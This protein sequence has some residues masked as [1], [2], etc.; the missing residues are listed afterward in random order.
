MNCTSKLYFPALQVISRH[1]ASRVSLAEFAVLN[2][3]VDRTWRYGKEEELVT[4]TQMME[5]IVDKKTGNVHHSGLNLSQSG[6]R[7][8]VAGLKEKGLIEYEQISRGR[9]HGN[10]AKVNEDMLFSL[11]QPNDLG[12]PKARRVRGKKNGT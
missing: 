1:W 11:T 6:C 4:Y 5:G 10:R 3:L 12:V 8:A 2:F 7:K 9:W